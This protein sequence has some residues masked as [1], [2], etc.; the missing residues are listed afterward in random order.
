MVLVAISKTISLLIEEFFMKKTAI[1][2]VI[3]ALLTSIPMF[4]A[5]SKVS[6]GGF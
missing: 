4:G 2:L 3:I 1:T 6:V 5:T